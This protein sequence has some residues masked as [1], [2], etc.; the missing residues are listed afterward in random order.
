MN[1][2]RAAAGSIRI[3]GPGGSLRIGLVWGKHQESQGNAMATI[4]TISNARFFDSTDVR[5]RHPKIATAGKSKDRVALTLRIEQIDW[6][7][8]QKALAE[9]CEDEIIHVC[10][11]DEHYRIEGN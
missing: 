7:T 3:P 11:P 5:T 6:P 2:T 1:K 8:L 4:T 10:G 9:K